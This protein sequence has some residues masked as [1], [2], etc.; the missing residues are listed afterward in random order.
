MS[1]SQ[2]IEILDTCIGCSKCVDVCPRY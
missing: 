1:S 2:L